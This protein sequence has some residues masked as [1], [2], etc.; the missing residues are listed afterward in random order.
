MRPCLYSLLKCSKQHLIKQISQNLKRRSIDF[1]DQTLST[2]PPGYSMM[3]LEKRSSHHS[4]KPLQM[5]QMI[6][7]LYWKEWKWDLKFLKKAKDLE[8]FFAINLKF[9]HYSVDSSHKEQQILDHPLYR[10]SSQVLRTKWG[11]FRMNQI[12]ESFHKWKVQMKVM[13]DQHLLTGPIS[14]E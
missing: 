5:K 11:S 13:V 4:K 3:N 7:K 14:K 10:W 9:D 2:F 12:K 1:S 6:R 8:D